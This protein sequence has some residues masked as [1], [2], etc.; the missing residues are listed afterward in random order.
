MRPLLAL[1]LGAALLAGCSSQGSG[2]SGAKSAA[3]SAAAQARAFRGSPAPLAALHTRH[4]QILDGGPDAFKARLARLKGHPVVV[5]KWASWCGP[6]RAEFPV[7]QQMSVRLGRKVAFVGVDSD[8]LSKADGASF[9]KRFP[10]SYPSYWDKDQKIAQV[11]NAGQ[12]MPIT[13]FYDTTG[14]LSYVH[15]GPYLSQSKLT[16]DIHR[17][18][19]AKDSASLPN[20][21]PN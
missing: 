21:S 1:A 15:S 12:G 4:N 19:G 13:A 2:G 16:A 18:T 11:F 3:P 14:K 10:L 17:Y 8:E 20:P 5:N 6:C 9:L 7:M